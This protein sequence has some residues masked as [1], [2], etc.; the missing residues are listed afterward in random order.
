[1]EGV[2]VKANKFALSGR[3]MKPKKAKSML[4]LEFR[5]VEMATIGAPL[6]I[7][8]EKKEQACSLLLDV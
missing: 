5:G 3:K 4:A 1:M 6:F 8:K 7:K 2:R